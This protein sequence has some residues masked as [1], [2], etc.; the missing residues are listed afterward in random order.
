MS[1]SSIPDFEPT[2]EREIENVNGRLASLERTLQTLVNHQRPNGPEPSPQPRPES[3]ST[4][5]DRQVMERELDYEGDSSFVAHSKH[6]TQAFEKSLGSNP[7]SNS[8]S[9]QDVSAAVATLR[10]FLNENS[11]S[12]D[13]SVPLHKPLQEAVQYP[14]LS[15]LDLP[16]M[17]PVLHLLR[18]CKSVLLF[19]RCRT[20]LLTL[21]S[22]SP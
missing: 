21:T 3:L 15:N 16:P 13:G 5:R 19:L 4:P 6:V 14:E 12:A 20:H 1:H 8:N 2:S 17:Q 9:A 11:P 18:W 10:S 7:Y 22:S